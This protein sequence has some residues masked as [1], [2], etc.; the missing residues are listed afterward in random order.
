[1]KLFERKILDFRFAF[2][3]ISDRSIAE[4]VSHGRVETHPFEEASD[5]FSHTFPSFQC[6]PRGWVRG[7]YRRENENTGTCV[8]RS[9]SGRLQTKQSD[10]EDWRDPDF[11]IAGRDRGVGGGGRVEDTRVFR[12]PAKTYLLIRR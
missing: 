9:V 2:K 5:I 1:M 11:E 10:W 4:P 8:I 12:V 3:L 7:R 6:D